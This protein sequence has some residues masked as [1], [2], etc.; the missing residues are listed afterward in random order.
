MPELILRIYV[1]YERERERERSITIDLLT[2]FHAF[3][4]TACYTA[5]YDTSENILM[6]LEAL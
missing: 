2:S 4:V 6:F 3:V 1:F 5:C